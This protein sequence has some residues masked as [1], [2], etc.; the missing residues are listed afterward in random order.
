MNLTIGTLFEIINDQIDISPSY[1][2]NM[3]NSNAPMMSTDKNEMMKLRKELLQ[4][5]FIEKQSN[6]RTILLKQIRQMIIS[7]EK[8]M[9]NINQFQML[10]ETIPREEAKYSLWFSAAEI[11][12]DLVYDLL[13]TINT[14]THI[15]TRSPHSIK[16]DMQH[17]CFISNLRELF[18]QSF[19]EILSLISIARRNLKV[20]T[21]KLNHNSSRSHT[22][23]IIKLLILQPKSE[24]FHSQAK[25]KKDDLSSNRIRL[26]RPPKVLL[27]TFCD[28]AGAERTSKT[29]AKNLQLKEACH[30]NTS[31]LTLK[32]CLHTL[33]TINESNNSNNSTLNST[34]SL[35]SC[36]NIRIP[37]RD[38][39][40]TRV[41]QPFFVGSTK[42]IVDRDVSIYNSWLANVVMIANIA[43]LSGVLEEIIQVLLFSSLTQ[44]IILP[45][46]QYRLKVKEVNVTPFKSES[47]EKK[48]N[49]PIM[50]MDLLKKLATEELEKEEISKIEKTMESSV[51]HNS[52]ISSEQFSNEPFH[53][54]SSGMAEENE[55]LKLAVV[56]LLDRVNEL[57]VQLENE[58]NLFQKRLQEKDEYHT[59]LYEYFTE[60][61][62]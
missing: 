47:I 54:I 38:S 12:N 1:R 51:L 53:D 4:S 28:L 15:D 36:K 24:E 3:F 5:K 18:V 19:D 17:N 10:M 42:A 49:V 32:R 46:K 43:P 37:F 60:E 13:T 45:S 6:D 56:K 52:D 21:T 2:P 39:K 44:N 50:T 41:L 55:S 23:F 11:Y 58:R 8:E 27:I 9:E 61:F 29:E 59:K 20:A 33:K 16:E 22:L 14:R 31:L 40:L 62:T 30:I 34:K 35:E 57:N 7:N 48:Q 26:K 25:R